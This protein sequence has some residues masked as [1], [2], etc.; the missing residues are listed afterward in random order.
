[1]PGNDIGQLY[2]QLRDDA[3][4]EVSELTCCDDY[5]VPME[6]I[7]TFLRA[8]APQRLMALCKICAVW[9]LN[10]QASPS[11]NRPMAESDECTR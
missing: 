4:I 9:S 11:N 10:V 6:T 7:F 5:G 8:D 3:T 1:M 2:T